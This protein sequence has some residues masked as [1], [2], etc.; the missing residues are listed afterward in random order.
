[1]NKIIRLYRWARF[2]HG[3]GVH[4]PFAFSFINDIVEEQYAYYGYKEIAHKIKMRTQ[5]SLRMGR[6][7][8]KENLFL[9]RLSLKF[10][11]SSIILLGCDSFFT[12]LYLQ[13]EKKTIHCTLIESDS[14]KIS[15]ALHLIDYEKNIRLLDVEKNLIINTFKLE[16]S[17]KGVPQIVY[18]H[19][20]L[21]MVD[22]QKATD[23][24]CSFRQDETVVIVDGINK[25]TA[26]KQF[27]QKTIS[28]PS[29]SVSFDLLDLGILVINPKLKKQNYKLFF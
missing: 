15:S 16:I 13:A 6:Y 12:L 21:S 19:Q 4:S 25:D 9:Y 2:R 22:K 27:W 29:I 5:P 20:S 10:N 8:L 1:M 11:P 3:H 24:C 18:I 23:L 17:K 26:M 7:R 14:S 28:I